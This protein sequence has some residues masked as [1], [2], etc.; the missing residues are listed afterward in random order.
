MVT[1]DDDSA[2]SAR[3]A[4]HCLTAVGGRL[5]PAS[6]TQS[7]GGMRRSLYEMVTFDHPSQ[8]AKMDT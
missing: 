5:V 3:P 6:F 4:I 1:P 8:T 2:D 7:T